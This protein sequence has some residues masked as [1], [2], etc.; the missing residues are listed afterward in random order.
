M[1]WLAKCGDDFLNILPKTDFLNSLKFRE[2]YKLLKNT[3]DICYP[4]F[5]EI[6]FIKLNQVCIK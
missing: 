5:A 2:E 6:M 3:A 4:K 1:P